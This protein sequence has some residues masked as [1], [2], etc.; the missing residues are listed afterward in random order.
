MNV[1]QPADTGIADAL[2]DYLR[3][4]VERPQLT[5]AEGPTQIT[6]GFET[7]TY[8]FRLAGVEGDFARPLILRRHKLEHGPVLARF[9]SA[10]QNA[11]ADQGFPSPR[12]LAAS[13]DALP[14]GGAFIIMERLP[15]VPLLELIRKPSPRT[16]RMASMLASAQAQLHGLDSAPLRNALDAEGLASMASVDGWLAYLHMRIEQR[17]VVGLQAGLTWAQEHRPTENASV[18]CHGDYHPNNVLIDGEAVSGVI[19][20]SLTKI[21]EPELDIG[22]TRVILM[23]G[24]RDVPSFLQGIAGIMGRNLARRYYAAYKKLR[25]VDDSRVRYYEA[26]RCLASLVWAS[27]HRLEAQAGVDLGPHP[28]AGKRESGRL[29]G[30]FR[31]ITGITLEVPP[32]A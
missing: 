15:G 8:A 10:V 22:N 3:Q 16:L 32:L 20:W 29:I 12:V 5:Y 13:S 26:V 9:E 31:K 7:L 19:D 1:T 23:L 24:P 18:I 30:H 28:W 27:E 14:L 4:H 21:T 11:V 17:E 6:G 25:P 2:L